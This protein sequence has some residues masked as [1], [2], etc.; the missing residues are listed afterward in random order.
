MGLNSNRKRKGNCSTCVPWREGLSGEATWERRTKQYKGAR[1]VKTWGRVFLQD[2]G[3]AQAEVLGQGR[4]GGRG[5]PGD[6]EPVRNSRVGERS[7]A[8][9]PDVFTL[10]TWRR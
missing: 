1:H 8:R 2:P 7:E 5:T 4:A 10:R 6:L 9:R 3:E